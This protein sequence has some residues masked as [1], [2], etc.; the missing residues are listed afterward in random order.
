MQ[1][2]KEPGE[3]QYLK[4]KIH[5]WFRHSGLIFSCLRT[6]N[7]TDRVSQQHRPGKKEGDVPQNQVRTV[8][9]SRP[10][11]Q[12]NM[13]PGTM[14]RQSVAKTKV[15]QEK[16]TWGYSAHGWRTE[17]ISPESRKIPKWHEN[18]CPGESRAYVT[19][20][21]SRCRAAFGEKAWQEQVNR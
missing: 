8:V 1:K 15:I 19:Y 5:K 21:G 6:Q 4:I 13:G 16:M 11:Q 20:P 9:W 10:S 7:Q 17:A 3:T 18:I 12:R 2:W 14:G